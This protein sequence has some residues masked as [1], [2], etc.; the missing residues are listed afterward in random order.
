MNHQVQLE[1]VANDGWVIITGHLNGTPIPVEEW[2]RIC[3]ANMATAVGRLWRLVEDEQALTQHNEVH[4][5]AAEAAALSPGV[6]TALHLPQAPPATLFIQ[7]KGTIEQDSFRVDY[8]WDHVS[9]RQI[10]TPERTGAFLTIGTRRYLLPSD[11]FGIVDAIDRFNSTDPSDPDTRTQAW[12]D[13]QEFMPRENEAG[14]IDASRYLRDVRVAH[15]GAFSLLPYEVDGEVRFDPVL[16]AAGR[17]APDDPDALGDEEEEPEPLLQGELQSV[18]ARDRF[19]RFQDARNCYSLPGGV[20][21][22]VSP[23]LREALKVTRKAQ[24]AGGEIAKEF[25]RNPRAYLKEALGDEL[26][27]HLI[28]GLFKE[29]RE[30]SERVQA[31]GLWEKKVLPWVQVASEAWLPPEAV[32]LI[33]DGAPIKLPPERLDGLTRKIEEA[34][35]QG[36]AE[37]VFDGIHIPASEQT[38]AALSE[39]KRAA[40]PEEVAVDEQDRAHKQER[41]PGPEP[42]VLI[43]RNNFESVVFNSDPRRREPEV[44]RQLYQ[45]LLRSQPKPHQVDGVQW[46]QD[47]WQ[48]GWT[49]ALL[50]D[51]MGLGKTFQTLAFLAWTKAAMRAGHITPAPVLIVAPTGLLRN[52]E[53]EH[54]IH[55]EQPG[56]GKLLRAYG[57]DLRALR[58]SSGSEL[59]LATPVLDVERIETADWILTTYETLRDYQHSFGRVRFSSI[60][61]DEAQ[62]VKTPGTQVTDA[63]KA[64]QA[65]FI[66]ALTGTPIENRLADL[67]CIMDTLHP[68]ALG[69][70]KDFSQRYEAAPDPEDLKH[71]KEV[72]TSPGQ[73]RPSVMLRRMKEEVLGALPPK[74]ERTVE[75]P[76]PDLQANAY[77]AVITAAR[78]KQ[79]RGKMLEALQAMRRVSLTPLERSVVA[80]DEDYLASS[81]RLEALVEILD[82][83]HAKG[84]KALLFVEFRDAQ[85]DLAGVLQRRYALPRAPMIISGNVSG[86]KRQERVDA[87]QA[88]AN[89]FNVMILSP[90]AGGVGLTLT[91]ANHVVHLT[92]WWNP[93]VEDQS[94]D[95]CYRIGQDKPVTVYYPMALLPGGEDHSFDRRLH[96]LLT[97]KRELSREM[98]MPPALSEEDARQLFEETIA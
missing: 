63:A 74:A 73:G 70:L 53:K 17:K 36:R 28:E 79:D 54:D 96:S 6:R 24:R 81:A 49:G 32:G 39:I 42:H 33:V 20:V 3:G 14:D 71:L 40:S 22:L 97:R 45:S 58:L 59:E 91:A 29:T 84:E 43:V 10:I 21:L 25:V 77:S 9:G 85:S 68:G 41:E 46:L 37:I 13:I 56:I 57:S 23:A 92:R 55:L 47:C 15:A 50:A 80:T 62:K 60:V 52:W 5:P 64:M 38:L 95:R 35:Q 78:Q 98:L 8:R 1:W 26:E 65:E 86:P 16:F 82:E 27:E 30:F 66:L 7:H 18:F 88:Q 76:M 69:G 90:K 4:L 83:I 12:L 34:I 61:F 89:G 48:T 67:W 51:D 31:I 44:P 11:L 75:R 19:A 94:T 93:A 72:L 2:P 87:F